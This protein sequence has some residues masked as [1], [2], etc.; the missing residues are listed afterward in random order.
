MVVQ[1]PDAE[2]LEHKSK[3]TWGQLD[4]LELLDF[5]EM[6]PK[7]KILKFSQYQLEDFDPIVRTTFPRPSLLHLNTVES[8]WS[9]EDPSLIPFIEFL[10]QNAPLLHKLVFRLTSSCR[11]NRKYYL[12]VEEKVRSMPRSSPTAEVIIT[13]YKSFQLLNGAYYKWSQHLL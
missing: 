6:F 5:L 8:T 13:K 1:F 4:L 12:M 2:F 11:E 3:E 9:A 10:L 7:L